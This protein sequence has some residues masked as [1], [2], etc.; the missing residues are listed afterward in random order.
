MPIRLQGVANQYFMKKIISVDFKADFGFF[1]KPDANNTVNLS[2]NILHKPA[3]LG[4][5]GAILG[6]DGYKELGKMP[7]YYNVLKDV[8]VGIEPLEHEKGVFQK[9]VIKYTNTVGYANNG[10]NYLTEEATL[11]KPTFRVY[12]LLNT[13]NENEKTLF[14]YLQDGKAEYIPYFGKN[15]FSAWW[16]KESFKDYQFED[17]KEIKGSIPIKTVFCKEEIVKHHKED[18]IPD[19]FAFDKEE[20]PFMYFER[21]PKS[22][23][24]KLIQYEL[25][26][27]ILTTFHI[28]NSLNLDSLYYLINENYYVQLL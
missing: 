26:D 3:L 23:D 21:I 25:G 10:S 2:Y 22:F 7:D 16:E 15:E 20:V 17:G 28:K 11:I 6:L 9:T 18:P 14:E 12:V 13:E 24:T 4:I 5:L 1:R 8:K 19:I 27:Y